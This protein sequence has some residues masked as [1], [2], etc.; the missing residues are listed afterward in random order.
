MTLSAVSPDVNQYDDP[1]DPKNAE[2]HMQYLKSLFE[3][4]N[5][6]LNLLESK[7][8]Q[9]IGQTGLIFSLLS[10][11]VPLLIDKLSSLPIYVKV[12]LLLILLA[13]FGFYLLTI[14]NALK[15]YNVK[16]FK[17]SSPSPKN[18]QAFREKELAK[19]YAEV[20]RDYLFALYRNEEIN[21]YKA[22]NLIQAYRSFRIANWITGFLVFAFCLILLFIKP[23]PPSMIIAKPVRIELPN[24][25]YCTKPVQKIPVKQRADTV[26][27]SVKLK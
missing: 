25:N 6:R 22:S 10:L 9:M 21:N 4:E 18:V 3:E 26:K 1:A 12:S 2:A 14:G 27:A 15:N 23:E 8:S 24:R 13:A 7:T 20:V 5:S 19:F 16:N 11:F 17:Y